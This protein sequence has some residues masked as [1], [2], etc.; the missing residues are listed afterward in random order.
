[1]VRP[2][3]GINERHQKILEYLSRRQDK[4]RYPP[5]IREIGIATGISSTSVVTYYLKQLEEMN[6]IERDHNVSRGVR[7]NVEAQKPAERASQAAR[8]IATSINELLNVP[9]IGRIFASDPIPVPASDFNYFD[10]ESNIQIARSLLP[11][12]EKTSELFALE[13]N[14]DSMIDAMVNNG[15][16]VI[17]KKAQT[18]E[19]GEM[20]AIWLKDED[21]TT[22]KYFFKEPK[23]IRLQPANPTMQPIMVKNPA[24]L[25]IQGKVVMVIRR[26][27]V[28]SS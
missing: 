4:Q 27:D 23:G 2:R 24:S 1:M 21:K 22:L 8:N 20:V 6:L 28:V 19:N 26:M 17:M 18:A 12:K 11:A 25:E 7:L 5:S 14:G 9:V 13:V 16:I 10:A 3:K 15:D